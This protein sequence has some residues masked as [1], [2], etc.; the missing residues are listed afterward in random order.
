M[1]NRL[2]NWESFYTMSYYSIGNSNAIGGGS[3]AKTEKLPSLKLRCLDLCAR[4]LDRLGNLGD[5][6]TE[7]FIDLLQRAKGKATPDIVQRL[8][9]ENMRL[10]CKEVD[11]AFWRQAVDGHILRRMVP[12]PGPVL[13]K[14]VNDHKEDLA[15]LQQIDLA[16]RSSTWPREI[17]TVLK[18]LHE[19]PASV[20]LLQQTMVGKVVGPLRK[21][22]NSEVAREASALVARWKDAAALAQQKQ[23]QQQQQ[24]NGGNKPNHSARAKQSPTKPTKGSGTVSHKDGKSGAV[25]NGVGTERNMAEEKQRYVEEGFRCR[26]WNTLYWRLETMREEK[27]RMSSK[28]AREARQ[29]ELQ[30]KPKMIMGKSRG[31]DLQRKTDSKGGR[32]SRMS[33]SSSSSLSASASASST[34]ACSMNNDRYGDRYGVSPAKPS[35]GGG[36]G[37]SSGNGRGFFGNGRG[38]GGVSGSSAKGEVTSVRELRRS[39]AI[40]QR[41]SKAVVEP[42]KRREGDVGRPPAAKKS[43]FWQ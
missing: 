26:T 39:V 20:G 1:R 17:V 5:M 25:A 24:S 13:V 40:G 3:L 18:A 10:M 38:G 34:S 2:A 41:L 12:A 28:R 30:K 7:M 14:R 16:E 21:A 6:P 36:G 15:Q 23:Q 33:M 31:E 22:D 11:G 9:D 43:K 27:V 4:H 42:G 32:R 35:N 37:S 29:L 8:Q 19:V